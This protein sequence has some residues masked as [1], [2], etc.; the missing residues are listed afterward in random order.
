MR[1]ACCN[2]E[3]QCDTSFL[4]ISLMN[5]FNSNSIRFVQGIHLS[6]ILPVSFS[7]KSLTSTFTNHTFIPLL[8]ANTL[9]YATLRY[10]TLLYATLLSIGINHDQSYK[11]NVASTTETET[12]TNTKPIKTIYYTVENCSLNHING[13]YLDHGK[14][15]NVPK[16]RNTRGWAIFRCSLMEIPGMLKF[17]FKFKYKYKCIY[18]YIYI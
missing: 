14:A 3:T 15:C 10:S 18:I 11:A 16:Y 13:R 5:E 7:P 6:T 1:S 9:L 12:N 2:V 4:A 17:K 8:F